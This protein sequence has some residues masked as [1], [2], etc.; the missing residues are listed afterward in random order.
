MIAPLPDER[1]HCPSC[2]T[3]SRRMVSL[4]SGGA[5]IERRICNQGHTW[6]WMKRTEKSEWE[7]IAKANGG[8]KGEAPV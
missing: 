7:L 5:T 2:K 8:D 6:R 4:T 3:R 1:E